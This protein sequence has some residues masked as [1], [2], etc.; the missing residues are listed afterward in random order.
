M[1]ALLM[2]KVYL[3]EIVRGEK[4]TDARLYPTDI[5]GTVVLGDSSTDKVYA[6]AELVDCR[7][8]SYERFVAWHRTGPFK[9]VEFAPYHEG[10]PCYE[11]VFS[12]VRKLTVPVTIPNPSGNRMWVEIP[13][14][15][16]RSF[17][18]QRTLFQ[19]RGP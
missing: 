4:S 7:E 9:D 3:D 18:Y 15:T 5:R 10:K 11:Y 14:E 19:F 6:T 8:I 2:M 12:D 17:G 1:H 16:V 13:E